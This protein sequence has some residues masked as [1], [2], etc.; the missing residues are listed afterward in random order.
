V[1]NNYLITLNVPHT[2]YVYETKP[3]LSPTQLFPHI[4]PSQPQA[5][6]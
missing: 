2:Q 6:S 3:P 1:K 5:A 4:K